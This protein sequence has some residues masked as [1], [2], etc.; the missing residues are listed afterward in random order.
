[1]NTRNSRPPPL[2][3]GVAHHSYAVGVRDGDGIQQEAIVVDPRR[4][5]HLTIAIETEPA[6]KDLREI[7]G[8]PGEHRG[9]PGAHRSDT[10]PQAAGTVNQSRVTH[11]Y[12]RNISDRVQ[13]ARDALQ[14]YP[15]VSGSLRRRLGRAGRDYECGGH[16]GSG[17]LEPGHGRNG[18]Q[19][20][21]A[22][23]VAQVGM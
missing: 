23:Q 13:W 11:G 19:I 4:A 21:G 2:D 20:P 16:R 8:S 3:H 18:R 6:G 12:T 17:G 9:H 1:M 7:A 10:H 5:R 22:I 15:K 14:R